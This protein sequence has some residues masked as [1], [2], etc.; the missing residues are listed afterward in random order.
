MRKTPTKESKV[1]SSQPRPSSVCTGHPQ[2]VGKVTRYRCLVRELCE[3]RS[4]RIRAP[5]FWVPVWVRSVVA[6]DGGRH[7]IGI[8]G[9]EQG[10][11]GGTVAGKDGTRD[12]QHGT[13]RDEWDVACISVPSSMGMRK[14]KG[15]RR[16]GEGTKVPC[17]M[18]GLRCGVRLALYLVFALEGKG[19]GGEVRWA[20]KKDT[21]RPACSI[22]TCLT[23]YGSPANKTTHPQAQVQ[24]SCGGLRSKERKG[25]AAL[26]LNREAPAPATPAYHTRRKRKKHQQGRSA[27]RSRGFRVQGRRQ[28]CK[29]HGPRIRYLLCPV[30]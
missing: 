7:G 19:G 25:D 27:E 14:R 21:Y 13:W 1:P 11:T 5:W 6:V 28:L 16:G 18:C 17:S 24:F 20:K 10:Q 8:G 26:H 2:I 15:R 29:E 4:I 12:S 23:G 22:R 30:S 3:R 9:L